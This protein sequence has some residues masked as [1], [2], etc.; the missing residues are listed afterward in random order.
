MSWLD[1]FFTSGIK[2]IQDE[3]TALTSEPY[4][5]FTGSGVVSTV[6]TAQNRI[7][8]TIAG[9]GGASS[10]TLTGDVTGTGT[11]TVAT[12]IAAA[13]VTPAK[14]TNRT[15]LS[16]F[17]NST[18]GA[19]SGEDIAAASDG[20]VMRRSGTALAFGAV[21]LASAN[22]VTGTLPTA[23]QVSQAMGGDVTG[24][25]AAAVVAKA[26]GA[27]VPAAGSLTTGNSLRVS[28]ASAL[29]YS[30][31]NLAGGAGFVTGVL[32]AANG[33]S[34]VAGASVM[35]DTYANIVASTPIGNRIGWATDGGITMWGDDGSNWNPSVGGITC[36]KIPAAAS[37]TDVN[38]SGVTATDSKGILN[39]RLTNE[40]SLDAHPFV[41]AIASPTLVATAAMSANTTIDGSTNRYVAWGAVMRE[42]STGKFAHII[43][44]QHLDSGTSP[45]GTMFNFGYFSNLTTRPSSN[46]RFLPGIDAGNVF[47]RIR[48]SAGNLIYEWSRDNVNWAQLINPSSGASPIAVTTAFTTG[49]NQ[50]GVLVLGTPGTDVTNNVGFYH[51]LAS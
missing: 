11:G 6:N 7:D 43:V 47:V 39:L 23:N 40:A 41:I 36:K 49:P 24:T 21:N 14:I 10:T 8:V 45:F 48:I 17:G 38:G 19:Q 33:G 25:T 51:Y 32:P 18:N 12:T 22:A 2:V 34:G 35:V 3:G 31:L 28:G 50:G 30:A 16:L 26:N 4:L 44:Q 42:S 27:T 46:D 13:S 29:T 5:N 1:S 20:Q 15:A 9:A 37:F